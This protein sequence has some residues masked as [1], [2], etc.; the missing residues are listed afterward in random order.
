MI[1]ENCFND[2]LKELLRNRSSDN[3][4]EYTDIIKQF[5]LTLNFYSSKAYD[6]LRTIIKLPHPRPKNV[7]NYS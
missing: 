6:Y 4:G 5:A 3:V 7:G 2:V 1:I